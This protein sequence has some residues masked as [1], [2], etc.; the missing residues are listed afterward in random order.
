[1][2]R[3]L[4]KALEDL[5]THYDGSV[6]NSRGDIIQIIYG[7]DG[8]DPVNMEDNN[9][10]ANLERIFTSIMHSPKLSNIKNNEQM[11]I[12]L[13]EEDCLKTD[14]FKSQ[15]GNYLDKWSKEGLAVGFI[16][17]VRD[18][19]NNLSNRIEKS[20]EFSA[21]YE[22]IHIFKINSKQLAK[23]M[24][25]VYRKYLQSKLHPGTAI[26]CISAQAI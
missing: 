23:F 20:F 17:K 10:P 12:D 11:E 18:F 26:G 4:V 13:D 7:D 2:Q 22:H 3:R 5:V 19:L 6:R 21:K 25:E 16:D 9:I 15:V 14:Q 1:M 24:D 8:L